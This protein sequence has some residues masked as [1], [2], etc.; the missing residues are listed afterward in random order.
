MFHTAETKYLT[1]SNLKKKAFIPA[2]TVIAE[3][4]WQQDF[5]AAGHTASS[6][7]KWREMSAGARLLLRIPSGT[8]EHGMVPLTVPTHLPTKLTHSRTPLTDRSGGLFPE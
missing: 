2:Q 1:R 6:I 7:R 3:K 4:A 8:P 5:E